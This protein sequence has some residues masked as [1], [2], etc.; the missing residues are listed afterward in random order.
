MT[1]H[2]IIKPHTLESICKVIADTS[3]GLTG[4]EIGKILADCKIVDTDPS[5]TKWKRLYNAFITSQNKHQ[6]S[7][8]ILR[9]V[10]T[11]MQPVRYL[12]DKE[13]F[14]LRRSA[15]N[16]VFSFIGIELQENG[17]YRKI[18]AVQTL[19]EAEN[20]ARNLRNEL[21]ERNVHEDVLE[22]CKAELLVDNYFHAVFEATKSV[23]DKIRRKT[24]LQYDGSQ[25]ID[26]TFSLKAPLLKINPLISET[27]K[28]EHT[29]F[30]NLLKGFF[31]M[32]RNT[33]A[34][35]P[36][37]KWDINE[38]DALD[39]MALASLMH[40]RLDTAEKP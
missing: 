34:H 31:G 25:L 15:L 17:K 20:R 39:I 37:I 28:S 6:C 33:L 2:P 7:N 29:G 36:K 26:A 9:F 19:T 27:D 16:K 5:M 40:R 1:K 3:L 24:G 18:E 38:R 32:F 11:A 23:A 35:E 14:E 12:S 22:F 10:Q 21:A 4:F 8:N 30:A 13:T